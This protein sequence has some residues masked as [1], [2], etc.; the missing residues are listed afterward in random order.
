L[1]KLFTNLGQSRHQHLWLR[2]NTAIVLLLLTTIIFATHINQPLFLW[3]QA[4]GRHIPAAIWA[5]L[6]SLGDAL[7][8]SVLLLL[9]AR[10]YP[11]M[12]WAAVLA[13]VVATLVVHGIKHT[14]A[15]PRPPA[16][17]PPD[18]LMLIGPGYKLD[19]FPSGHSATIWVFVG[20]WLMS[21]YS[22]QKLI[23]LIVLATLVSLSRV[24]VGAHWPEDITTGALIGWLGAWAGVELAKRWQWGVTLTGQ[25]IIVTLLLVAA[26]ALIGHDAGYS[27][28]IYVVDII[29]VI[30]LA[31]GGYQVYSLFRYPERALQISG[32]ADT[33]Q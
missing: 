31:V 27:Q 3:L 18:V 5:S 20:I 9:F 2:I 25:R 16:V 15:L 29:A 1:K 26:F 28:A 4:W 8:A 32:G 6:T 17:V 19:S 21:R 7:T 11:R 22:G 33:P 30:C 24:M 23:A 13:G 12:V 10:K 14:L